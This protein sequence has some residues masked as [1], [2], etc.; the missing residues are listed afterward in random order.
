MTGLLPAWLVLRRAALTPLKQSAQGSTTGHSR[1]RSALVA[2]QVAVSL[3]LLSHA[4]VSLRSFNGVLMAVPATFTEQLVARFDLTPVAPTPVEARRIADEL[5]GRLSADARIGAVAL[6]RTRVVH[7]A[8]A[9]DRRQ[10]TRVEMTPSYLRVMDLSLLAGR[11]LTAADDGSVVLASAGLAAR[12]S[13][14]GSAIGHVLTIDDDDRGARRVQ[15]VGVVSDIGTEPSTAPPAPVLYAPLGRELDGEFALRVRTSATGPVSED[16]RTVVRSLDPRMTWVSLKRGDEIYLED[17]L[18]LRYVGWAVGFCGVIALVLAAT[19]LYAV[20]SYA[21]QLRRREIGVRLAIGA[22]PR[23]I[24]RLIAGQA[25]RLIIAG[26]TAGLAFG[27][28]LNL[29]FKAVS[30]VPLTPLDPMAYLPT[31]TML[32]VVGMLAAA[33]PARRAAT[34]DPATT[35]RQD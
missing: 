20:I 16:M 10:V 1:L 34:I 13:P 2:A 4:V 22:D 21:V 30:L 19:G 35:L 24:V 26:A 28:P 12:I 29:G 5:A 32:F 8:N 11:T 14:G 31:T 18:T 17:A 27:L 7:Y 23:D 3:M 6:S 9:G 33:L 15:V 25:G